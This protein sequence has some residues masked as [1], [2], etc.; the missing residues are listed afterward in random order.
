MKKLRILFGMCILLL[1]GLV[2]WLWSDIS[3]FNQS[4]DTRPG[5]ETQQAQDKLLRLEDEGVEKPE[6][7]PQANWDRASRV[8][9]IKKSANRKVNF[10]GK[11]VDQHGNPVEGV[12]L[13][14]EILSYQNSFIDY[15]KTGREQ[16][17][18]KFS[19]T[20]DANGMFS[21]EKKEG[22]TFK[23]EKMTKDGY[24]AMSNW[25]GRILV[26]LQ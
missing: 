23:I 11:L 3:R 13:D 20:T 4:S 19:M 5:I 6:G 22:T 14:L 7:M 18:K 8:H 15:L 10:Y 25:G 17:V 1:A 21:V 26:F 24:D 9:A 16:I 2:L 12:R